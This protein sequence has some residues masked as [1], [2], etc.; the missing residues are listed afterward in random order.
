[1]LA[2]TPLPI[3]CG[4]LSTLRYTLTRLFGV[5]LCKTEICHRMFDFK[6]RHSYRRLWDILR[7]FTSFVFDI[8]RHL[9]QIDVAKTSLQL[10]NYNPKGPS[11]AL[12]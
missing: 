11:K 1:M 3:D 5:S 10:A 4:N 2:H 12:I 8:L 7:T 9:G 6:I